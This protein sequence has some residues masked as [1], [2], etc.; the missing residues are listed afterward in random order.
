MKMKKLFSLGVLSLFMGMTAMTLAG[1]Q[2]GNEGIP[3]R[4]VG[5][6]RLASLELEGC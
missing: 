5:A 4:F 1:S 2:I 3:D 6:W